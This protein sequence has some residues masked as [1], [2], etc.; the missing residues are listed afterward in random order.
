MAEHDPHSTIAGGRVGQFG[1]DS[2]RLNP[3]W[4]N[5]VVETTCGISWNENTSSTDIQVMIQQLHGQIQ[6][7]YNAMPNDGAYLNEVCRR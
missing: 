2:A 6:T 1:A 5:A 7:M 4:R 3:A